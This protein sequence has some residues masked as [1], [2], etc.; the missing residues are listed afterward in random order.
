[1]IRD[2]RHDAVHQADVQTICIGQAASIAAVLLAAGT[3]ASG[4]SAVRILIH[5]PWM[6][7]LGGQ[8]PTS[9]WRQESCGCASESTRSSCS[10]GQQAKT[11]QDDTERDYIMSAD[12]E[13]IRYYR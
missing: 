11:D 5:Q 12:Q 7:G 2:L 1:L 10:T 4:I 13:G 8:P 3:R 6:S 9:T